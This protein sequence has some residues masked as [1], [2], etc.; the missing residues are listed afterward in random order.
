MPIVM[1]AAGLLVVGLG[2]LGIA[3]RF[4]VTVT[5]WLGPAVVDGSVGH[6]RGVTT[7]LFALVTLSGLVLT[8]GGFVDLNL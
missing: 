8:L 4:D 1:I 5:R 7:L 6:G 3:G 2:L